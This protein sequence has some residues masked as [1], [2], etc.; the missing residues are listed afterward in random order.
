[1]NT[2]QTK[3]IEG[4]FSIQG[5][6]ALVTG[7]SSGIGLMIAK[8]YVKAGATV[9]ISSR[10]AAVCQEVAESLSKMGR[11]YA[12]PADMTK[13]EDRKILVEK[14]RDQEGKLSILVNN[15]GTNWGTSIEK[16]SDNAFS[17][18]MSLNVNAVFSLTR[19]LLP[20]L[21]QSGIDGDPARVINIG[22]MDG[23]HVPVVQKTGTF[24]Y[25]AS[26]AAVHHLTKTLAVELGPRN[27]TVNAI[28]PGFFPSKMTQWVLDQ[29][30]EDIEA[31]C[32]LNRVGQPAEM[33]GIAIYLAS[34]AGAYTNGTIIPVDGG[35][36]LSKQG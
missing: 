18:V 20:L 23:I 34:R 15:A 16:F 24:A 6:S 1:M 12:I 29:Y 35:T 19:D 8:G 13:A 36:H 9:Y 2:E 17:K 21:D 28:A 22:S 33:A 3:S 5:K 4:L 30:G 31:S 11:C 7:G 25:S 10:K 14:I 26:K 32:P 27:I